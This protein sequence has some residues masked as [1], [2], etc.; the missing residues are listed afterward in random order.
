[1]NI[2]GVGFYYILL[3]ADTLWT[4]KILQHIVNK[5]KKTGGTWI[6]IEARD[7]CSVQKQGEQNGCFGTGA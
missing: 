2:L 5:N 7:G 4:E 3:T 6:A 1:M